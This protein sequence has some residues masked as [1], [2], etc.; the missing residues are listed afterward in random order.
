MKINCGLFLHRQLKR[1]ATLG[2]W[3]VL[4]ATLSLG[5]ARETQSGQQPSMYTPP[6]VG[7]MCTPSWPNVRSTPVKITDQ[8]VLSVPVKYLRDWWVDC[9]APVAYRRAPNGMLENVNSPTFDF[10]LPDFSGYTIKRYHERF[11]ADEVRVNLVMPTEARLKNKEAARP[12]NQVQYWLDRGQATTDGYEEVYGLKCY[13]ATAQKGAR[14]CYSPPTAN[15]DEGIYIELLGPPDT[16]SI[17]SATYSSKR[18]GGITIFWSMHGDHLAHWRD[19]DD[20]IWRFLAEWNVANPK[21]PD[22]TQQ[23]GH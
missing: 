18:Y 20:Q 15:D 1:A 19:V 21:G 6:P 14:Y 16:S 23:G 8:L 9:R 11:A 3:L 5:H 4:V 22:V 12:A 10:F 17:M 13:K 7:V 2:L